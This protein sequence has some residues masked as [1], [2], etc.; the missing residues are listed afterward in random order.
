MT[1]SSGKFIFSA[2]L[3]ECVCLY[4]IYNNLQ[5][6]LSHPHICL[7]H[8][9]FSYFLLWGY[10]REPVLEEQNSASSSVVNQ[11]C[12]FKK[13]LNFSNFL[14]ASRWYMN[15]FSALRFYLIL[16]SIIFIYYLVNILIYQIYIFLTTYCMQQAM[17][18]MLAKQH[19]AYLQGPH[20]L[21]GKRE[22]SWILNYSC[23]KFCNGV[24]N[25]D[26]D[27]VPIWL[28]MPEKWLTFYSNLAELEYSLSFLMHSTSSKFSFPLLWLWQLVFLLLSPTT[29][30]IH[31]IGRI[32]YLKH[33]SDHLPLLLPRPPFKDFLFSA[34][35]FKSL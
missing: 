16:V 8:V 25:R 10:Y 5:N 33:K 30:Q 15:F 19:G 27:H 28:Y 20:T 18:Q 22:I 14:F 1:K 4:I 24:S 6:Y 12:D 2:L 31:I 7:L 32:T 3:W 23:D 21:W 26:L 17:C 35:A 9:Q 34:M 11:L 13:S 29:I